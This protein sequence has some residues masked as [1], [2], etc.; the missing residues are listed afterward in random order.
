MLLS[1]FYSLAKNT[2][3]KQLK[4]NDL[5]LLELTNF[6]LKEIYKKF[7]ISIQEQV[8][9]LSSTVN[10]YELQPDFM[11]IVSA[12]TPEMYLTD[13]NGVV[14]NPN[15][16]EIIELTVNDDSDPNTVYFPAYN[17]C[18]FSFPSD[19]QQVS[20]IYKA[21]PKVIESDD[22]DSRLE[23]GDQYIEP[24]LFYVAYL[25]TMS[26]SGDVNGTQ[27]NYLSKYN[28]ACN[29]IKDLSLNNISTLEN[30]NLFKKGFV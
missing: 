14:L 1:E 6:G 30:M 11:Q 13:T 20:L 27:D 23:I 19:N 26:Y 15:S 21:S 5:V 4:V 3:L 17:K 7:N 10:E 29:K 24:L 25:Y 12:Y 2:A 18:M 9:L 28:F 16:T 8:L 22:E